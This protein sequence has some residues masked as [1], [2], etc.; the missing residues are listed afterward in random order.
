MH[1][2]NTREILNNLIIFLFLWATL[3][4]PDPTRESLKA[5]YLR[6]LINEIVTQIFTILITSYLRELEEHPIDNTFAR[7]RR[8]RAT[9]LD[10]GVESEDELIP[11]PPR[12]TSTVNKKNAPSAPI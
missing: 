11:Q 3:H 10:S 8:S 7:F 4:M 6:K 1:Y 12:P 5:I 2:I 9:S